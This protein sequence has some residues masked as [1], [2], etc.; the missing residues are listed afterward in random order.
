[1]ASR[2]NAA[3]LQ[4]RNEI[5]RSHGFTSY[6]QARPWRAAARRTLSEYGLILPRNDQR[7]IEQLDTLGHIMMDVE[8]SGSSGLTAQELHEAVEDIFRFNDGEI[9]PT[10][11]WLDDELRNDDGNEVPWALIRSFYPQRRLAS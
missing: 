9:D 10:Y 3:T 5:A 6:S 2:N 8:R 4:R 11:Y 7:T 1:M